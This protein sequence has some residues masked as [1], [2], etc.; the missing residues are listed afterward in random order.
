MKDNKKG[1]PISVNGAI[2]MMILFIFLRGC[3]GFIG[4]V[5]GVLF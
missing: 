4:D 5:G 1:C 2:V 3:V